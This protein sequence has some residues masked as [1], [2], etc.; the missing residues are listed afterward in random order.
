MDVQQY[1]GVLSTLVSHGYVVIAI[2]N[3]FISPSIKFPGVRIVAAASPDDKQRVMSLQYKLQ[4]SFTGQD[5]MCV[6][7][8][9]KSKN[10][11]FQYFD[12]SSSSK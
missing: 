6:T 10:S 4:R 8:L 12:K 1:I 11:L 9:I 2:N 5:L 3:T 7:D